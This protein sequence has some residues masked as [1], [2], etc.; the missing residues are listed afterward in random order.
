M[1]TE[2]PTFP[3]TVDRMA[4]MTPRQFCLFMPLEAHALIFKGMVKAIK[5]SL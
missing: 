4:A 2:R 5:K 3:I 1:V